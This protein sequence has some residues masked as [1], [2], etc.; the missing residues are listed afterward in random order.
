MASSLRA[1]YK[2][3]SPLEFK[4]PLP[5]PRLSIFPTLPDTVY[6][7]E[8]DEIDDLDDPST[9]ETPNDATGIFRGYSPSSS[10]SSFSARE[11][12]PPITPTNEVYHGRKIKR[13]GSS[14][15]MR[16]SP[17]INYTNKTRLS[18]YAHQAP[19]TP[20]TPLS[21]LDAFPANVLAVVT[22]AV[23][24]FQTVPIHLASS[25][26]STAPEPY[27]IIIDE[28]V[29]SPKP[30]SVL[31]MGVK[32]P[33]RRRGHLSQQM[34][35]KKPAEPILGD[36]D[37]SDDELEKPPQQ[38][39]LK[40]WLALQVVRKSSAPAILSCKNME[41]TGT[42]DSISD[43]AS[44]L[45][46]TCGVP[47]LNLD[48][49]SDN[50]SVPSI[51]EDI[52]EEDE[53]DEE[54]SGVVIE[55]PV[56]PVEVTAE[57]VI[58]QVV[59]VQDEDK[60]RARILSQPM[61]SQSVVDITSSASSPKKSPFAFG[62]HQDIELPQRSPSAPIVTSMSTVS[63]DMSEDFPVMFSELPVDETEI[64]NL[65]PNDY[66]M[67]DVLGKDLEELNNHDYQ[68]SPAN[69]EYPVHPNWQSFDED[70]HKLATVTQ[71]KTGLDEM[72][73][74]MNPDSPIARNFRD[75]YN[76][77]PSMPT[78]ELVVPSPASF[79]PNSRWSDYS[80]DDDAK[81]SWR[82]SVMNRFHLPHVGMD[83]KKAVA[84]AKGGIINR[85][86]KVTVES[87]L[88]EEETMSI[89]GGSPSPRNST[90][91]DTDSIAETTAIAAIT[92]PPPNNR[93]STASSGGGLTGF[94]MGRIGSGG[95][96]RHGKAA[97]IR[98]VATGRA[99]T[100]RGA[101]SDEE[102]SDDEHRASAGFKGVFEKYVVRDAKRRK[103]DRR[104]E[105]LKRTIRVV[106]GGKGG[107]WI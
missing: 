19:T 27:K 55:Q 73:E 83:L 59:E 36:W 86:Q 90:A 68:I 50:T 20:T 14:A 5:E 84:A 37:T 89:H 28:R 79:R 64:F 23:T 57:E 49:S 105:E 58:E 21:G 24:P 75:R 47:L 80:V 78:T 100:I 45:N 66:I 17:G 22:P 29:A 43:T 32:Y 8:D 98:T 65:I 30:N 95:S 38:A 11:I 52:I 82:S 97:S 69:E 61:Y 51:H 46:C 92:G 12:S 87:S 25:R 48:S 85:R 63:F 102:L 96:I 103:D 70:E 4:K 94:K 62:G 71:S 1:K 99:A 67:A 77:T 39:E 10:S 81:E 53:E 54:E 18:K 42:L 91:T 6:H 34:L 88:A 93:N 9:P 7:P 26:P 101:S 72:V 106:G 104:R 60:A 40:P 3:P 16:G 41:E 13:K 15:N 35:P 74:M 31:G 56:E 2:R 44:E 107:D 76:S 33:L